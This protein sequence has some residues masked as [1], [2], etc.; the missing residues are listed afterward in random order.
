V[1]YGVCSLRAAGMALR[2]AA[3][4]MP[5]GCRSWRPCTVCIVKASGRRSAPLARAFCSAGSPGSELAKLQAEKLNAMQKD[6]DVLNSE[7]ATV[8]KNKLQAVKE[9]W[10]LEAKVKALSKTQALDAVRGEL[11]VLRNEL[12]DEIAGDAVMAQAHGRGETLMRKRGALGLGAAAT[13]CTGV[14]V[15]QFLSGATPIDLQGGLPQDSK[16]HGSATAAGHA[17]A[18]AGGHAATAGNGPSSSSRS[19][20]GPD[21]GS[22]RPESGRAPVDA[23][24]A[25][26]G[27]GQSL[28]SGV[29]TGAVAAAGTNQ[30]IVASQDGTAL[31]TG[32]GDGGAPLAL[33]SAAQCAVGAILAAGL[34]V[35]VWYLLHAGNTEA[36][37]R[38]RE[39]VVPAAGC[40]GMEELAPVAEE[41]CASGVEAEAPG[42]AMARGQLD[43]ACS[44]LA[45]G[46]SEPVV[47]V[48]R[49][50]SSEASPTAAGLDLG[51]SDA[52]LKAKASVEDVFENTPTE[53]Q[54][55]DMTA[56]VRGVPGKVKSKVSFFDKQ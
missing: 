52:A 42:T 11:Q 50:A 39:A 12:R 15:W 13:L 40:A 25:S 35:G 29:G 55:W 27:A 7:I 36:A 54:T 48:S 51:S 6:L 49:A 20:S 5:R 32:V 23:A 10:S 3:W 30:G 8:T 26:G 45:V 19:S 31:A 56:S 53:G 28:A 21:S 24:G 2:V 22:S 4:S 44:S 9:K 14:G 16:S 1:A 46:R 17:T 33:P 18:Q 34:A 47:Q 37:A 43:E 41:A 38:G